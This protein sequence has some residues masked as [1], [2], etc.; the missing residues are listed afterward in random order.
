M[1]PDIN[2]MPPSVVPTTKGPDGSRPNILYIMADEAIAELY[3]HDQHIPAD[4]IR[5]ALREATLR[6][7]VVPV[8]CGS[9]FKNKGVQ[10]L[11]SAVIDYLPS[12]LDVEAVIGERPGKEGTIE[13]KAEDSEPFSALVFKLT[14][15]KHVG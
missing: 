9:A 12:P 2:T 11:L 15:D 7:E 4:Q 8:L 10:P 3:L 6:L 13:R 5:R 1:A 14:I